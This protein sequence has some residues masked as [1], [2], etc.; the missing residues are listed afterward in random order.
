MR[1]FNPFI[2]S[3]V[4]LA[5][6]AATPAF[7]QVGQTKSDQAPP[8][9]LKSEQEIK[10]GQAAC[11]PTP[12]ASLAANCTP[13]TNEEITVTG[14]RI[15]RPNLD[16]PLPVTSVGGQ[17]FFQTGNVSVGDKLAELP[18]I[19]STFTQANSTRFLGAAGINKLDLRGLGTVRTLVLVNGRRHVGGD[20]LGNG[21]T[22]DINTI[23]TDLIDRVDV[24]TGGNS[25]VYGSDAIAG[26]VNFV[27]KQNYQGLQLR[28]QGGL[29]RYGDAG[30]FF[31][32]ALGGR[33][34]ADGRGNITVNAEFAKQNQYFASGR[35]WLDR[36]DAFLTVDSDPAGAPNGSDGVPDTTFFRDVRSGSLTNT[37]IMRFGGTTAA[38][39]CGTDPLGG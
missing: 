13:A 23:P 37:G 9:A 17:E 28:G 14:S 36:Q 32:S 34:F 22:P 26:V 19:R 1:R 6:M 5:A 20:V 25:A 7:A 24:V 18:S 33:N 16:S 15:R 38:N 4:S 30:S 11:K 3:T 29:S 8:R 39:S 27:L 31:V 2:L 12:G 10:S 35:P 21:V